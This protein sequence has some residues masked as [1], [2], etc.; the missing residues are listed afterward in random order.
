[1]ATQVIMPKFGMAQEDATIL[2][3]L[4][5]D[6]DVVAQGDVLLEVQ[7]DKVNMEVESPASGILQGILA[8]EGQVVPV[9]QVIAY[10]LQPG[11][12]LRT[13]DEHSVETKAPIPVHLL[14]SDR[15]VTPVAQKMLEECG[16]DPRT[17]PSASPSQLTRQDV[18]KF[19]EQKPTASHAGQL[20]ATPA[21]RRLAREQKLDLATIPGTGPQGRVQVSDVSKRAV[22][23]PPKETILAEP[24]SAL[25]EIIPLQGIRRAIANRMQA[26]FQTAPH[27]SFTV[28]VDMT[29]AQVWRDEMNGLT[30]AHQA[31][32][33][34]FTALLVKVCA[35]AL[36]RHRW[37]NASLREDGIHLHT[38]ANIG[39]AVAREDGLIVPV[40]HQADRLNLSV[41]TQRLHDMATRAKANTLT[42]DDV[43]G[44]TF[45]ISNLGMFGIDEFTAIINPPESAILAVGRIFKRPQVNAQDQVVPRPM[46]KMTLSADHRVM[47]GAAAAL[48]LRD[49]VSALEKPNLLLW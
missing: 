26:S 39:V 30:K 12:S 45:T 28:E 8:P 4:K 1:M 14:K 29:A 43:S 23:Q 41:I 21:A 11:E 17:V 18:E 15:R 27:I 20:R 31:P 34:S 19:L 7:T 36:I 40:I 32:P 2:R 5:H 24:Q 35:W 3:W 44:G 47:D 9:T 49:V 10:V 22:P 42:P 46:M 6:G 37:V 13:N 25:D 33:V 16:V 38:T 48:F